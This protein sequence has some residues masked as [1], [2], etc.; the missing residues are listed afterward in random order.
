[1]FKG[2]FGWID[3]SNLPKRK[4]G[5]EIC[6]DWKNSIG[7]K[8]KFKYKDLNGELEII[9]YVKSGRISIKYK[10]N[11][12]DIEIVHFKRVCIGKLTNYR[13]G[14]FK[15]KI[16]EHVKDN[17]R[18]LVII[19]KKY[20]KDKK[21]QNCKYYKYHCNKCGYEGWAIESG[22]LTLGKGCACCSR[23][24]TV[25]GINDIATT[26]PWMIEYLVNEED[27]YKYTYGSNIK[28]PMKCLDCGNI[29]EIRPYELNKHGFSCSKCGD[30]ISYPEKFIFSLL[31]QLNIDFKTQYSPSWCGMY[32]YDF[33]IPNKELIVEVHG[34]QHYIQ[35]GKT[36]KFKTLKEQ[37]KIDN[38]KEIL[39][40][41]NGIKHY[42]QLDCR[43]SSLEFIKNS[44]LN[45]ELIKLFDLNLV[46]WNVCDESSTSNLAKNI[47]D[48]YMRNKD[49]FLKD[50]AN[51]FKI[52]KNT[53][54]K[55]LKKGKELGWCDHE[56]HSTWRYTG[57]F[58]KR[59]ICI[60]LQEIFKSATECSKILKE[61]YNE[62][63]LASSI[64]AVCR[65]DRKSHKG[66]HFEY[67][68]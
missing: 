22:L 43:E 16:H 5:K 68:D 24:V 52:G 25:K 54:S 55:Y 12:L 30:G 29:K 40:K 20:K 3:D 51:E 27:A 1:M 31:Y 46:N 7:C 35:Q 21:G 58:D 2:K 6:V 4:R 9:K 10:D 28:V 47:C 32:R 49:M 45:S 56:E 41:E 64:S 36:S 34:L 67:V 14:D 66:F 13:T 65:G 26:D 59:V 33:Y 44:V 39:A 38:R 61:R 62:N 19:D 11:I 15:I 23:T 37:Q 63:F 8:C 50:I 60:E 18:D 48:Y 53:V 42:I 57:V 17:K